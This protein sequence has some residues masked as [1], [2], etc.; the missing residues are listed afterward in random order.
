VAQ[1]ATWAAAP[2]AVGV[3][4]AAFVRR[5]GRRRRVGD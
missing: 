5:R 2:I 1:M 4:L 3:A